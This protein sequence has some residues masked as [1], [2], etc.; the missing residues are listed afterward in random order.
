MTLQCPLPMSDYGDL[1]EYWLWA[2][3][4]NKNDKTLDLLLTNIGWDRH[5]LVSLEKKQEKK[6]MSDYSAICKWDGNDRKM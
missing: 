1:I 3:N 4:E 5:I 2:S 6:T